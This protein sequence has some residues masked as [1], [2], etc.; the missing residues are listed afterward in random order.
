MTLNAL[1]RRL[2]GRRLLQHSSQTASDVLGQAVSGVAGYT[3]V[4][5]EGF[6]LEGLRIPDGL[7]H[8]VSGKQGST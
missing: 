8:I 4:V 5:G 6:L 7:L 2:F 3:Q 1:V